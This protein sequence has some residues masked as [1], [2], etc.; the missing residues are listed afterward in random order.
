MAGL[1]AHRRSAKLDRDKIT[2]CAQAG[3]AVSRLGRLRM[4]CRPGQVMFV[5][6]LGLGGLWCRTGLAAD[7]Q[8][9]HT[10]RIPGALG[11]HCTR[12]AAHPPP[13]SRSL[14]LTTPP[15]APP[16]PPPSLLRPQVAFRM[17]VASRI[18]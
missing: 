7:A 13:P 4:V 14:L 2:R 11:L 17:A 18:C 9:A 5:L 15:P 12:S 3:P 8:R 16:P 1:A 10:D 6:W